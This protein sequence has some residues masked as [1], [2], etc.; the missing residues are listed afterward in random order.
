MLA[1]GRKKVGNWKGKEES[2]YSLCNPVEKGKKSGRLHEAHSLHGPPTWRQGRNRQEK[3]C[4]LVVNNYE[5]NNIKPNTLEKGNVPF[6]S[7]L[8]DLWLSE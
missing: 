1:W 5:T 3:E 4:V 6:P 7:T 2:G 8:L